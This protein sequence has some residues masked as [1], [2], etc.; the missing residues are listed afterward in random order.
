MASSPS[1]SDLT[2][3]AD[4]DLA[5]IYKDPPETPAA[6]ALTELLRRHDSSLRG[7][8]S[9]R[10]GR[11]LAE[12]ALQDMRLRLWKYRC[13]YDP[14]RLRWRNWAGMLLDQ[15]AIDLLRRRAG[16]PAAAEPEVLAEHVDATTREQRNDFDAALEECLQA[17][18]L[19]NRNLLRRRFWQDQNLEEIADN[20]SL[21]V[22]TVW[23]RLQT[24]LTKLRDCVETKV[25]P[26]AS[27]DK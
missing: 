15:V 12:D 21:A 2:R 6:A 18:S 16:L 1:P 9:K 13:R 27:H 26:E 14:G 4:D 5:R 7:Q 10:V 24:L 25:R 22:S 20:Q 3:L 11:D 17:L 23:R 8:V 19:E